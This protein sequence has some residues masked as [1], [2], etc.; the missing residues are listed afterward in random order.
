MSRAA[1]TL[2][3]RERE[4]ARLAHVLDGAEPDVRLIEICGDPWIGKTRLLEALGDLAR[5]R[6][7]TVASGVAGPLPVTLSFGVFADALDDLFAAYGDDLAQSIP[8]YHTWW[9]AG[10]FPALASGATRAALPRSP[11][12][13]HHAFRA[14]RTALDHLGEVNRLLLVIDDV[15]WAD[16]ASVELLN[17][18]VRHP[19]AADVL[20]AVAYRPRQAPGEFQALLTEAAGMGGVARIDVPPLSDGDLSELLP[21]DLSLFQHHGLVE[22][23]GGNPGLGQALAALS[24]TPGEIADDEVRVTDLALRPLRDFCGLSPLGWKV[25]H[26]AAIMLESVDTRLLGEIAQIGESEISA[27][28]DE[29][30]RNDVLRLDD[31]ERTFSFRHPLLRAA[32]YES[33]GAAWRLGAHAR[34]AAALMGREASAPEV[35]H[36]LRHSAVAG[37]EDSA[38]VLLEAARATL[39]RTPEEA[40][41]WIGTARA[42]RRTADDDAAQRAL[43]ATALTLSGDLK[44]GLALFESLPDTGQA[45]P[46]AIGVAWH[47]QALRLL[48]RHGEAGD[49]VR[50]AL[51]T[52]PLTGK[53]SRARLY[54]ALGA[55]AIES[56]RTRPELVGDAI[57]DDA[58][59]AL[60]PAL[61]VLCLSLLSF[62]EVAAGGMGQA[63]FRIRKAAKLVEDLP[64][65]ELLSQLDCLYWLGHAEILLDQDGLAR[66][67][68]QRALD[69]AWRYRQLSLVPQTATLLATV[70]LRLGQVG[71][72]RLRAD[73]AEHVARRIGSAFQADH[74]MRLKERI[75]RGDDEEIAAPAVLSVEEPSEEINAELGKLSI[76]ERE[77]AVLVSDGRTNQQIARLLGLSHKTVETYLARIFK[78][79]ELCSRAQLATM[80]GR[81]DSRRLASA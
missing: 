65:E 16:Q 2:Y 21:D 81:S 7:W 33:A 72:A 32:A 3:G 68:L 49:L 55:T 64:D 10:I 17:H 5:D 41:Q 12:E 46:D 36:H 15:Q 6:G 43:L 19:P 39:W 24:D 38:Q 40:V 27:G 74:A 51:R 58:A 11:S 56:G 20:L 53:R 28:V 31:T 67:H 8:A 54:A 25:A 70:L 47:A 63:E 48:G 77:I 60:D 22:A 44:E 75:D 59:E 66:D 52:V 62:A 61:H 37:D 76:R 4:L 9:M 71:A 69:L 80:V 50:D 30:V 57:L 29:L 42:L 34:A 14:I 35:A 23:S 73:Q 1:P 45:R 13:M 78:K 26:A 18:L 79:L